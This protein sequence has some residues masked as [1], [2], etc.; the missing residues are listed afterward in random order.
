MQTVVMANL[1]LQLVTL[2]LVLLLFLLLLFS[3]LL[4][5]LWISTRVRVPSS[6]ALTLLPSS[7]RVP[8]GFPAAA[9]SLRARRRR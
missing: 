9:R 4:L 6:V 2:L 7:E 3:L 8:R 1:Q 5:L